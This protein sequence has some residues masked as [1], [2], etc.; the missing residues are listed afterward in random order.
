M[1]IRLVIGSY[2]TRFAGRRVTLL[3]VEGS[4]FP[5]GHRRALS[6]L[7]PAQRKGATAGRKLLDLATPKTYGSQLELEKAEG[8]LGWQR[9]KQLRKRGAIQ[10]YE[11]RG[12]TPRR[13]I[14][15]EVAR[16]KKYGLTGED[17]ALLLLK[18]E[19]A[20]LGCG[21]NFNGKVDFVIDHDHATGKVRGLL[22]GQCNKVLAHWMT[23]KRLRRLAKYL[24][25]A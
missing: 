3:L 20:C 18:Q 12:G 10:V 22:C 5:L 15:R 17:V 16:Y 2:V 11:M 1:E 6:D 23:P 9:G 24:E 21:A 8:F 19:G 14:Q 25:D 4:I 13:Q 7:G